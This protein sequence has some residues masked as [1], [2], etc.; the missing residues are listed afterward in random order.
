MYTVRALLLAIALAA[1]ACSSDNDTAIEAEAE[2]PTT[3]AAATTAASS[4]S[5]AA[6]SAQDTDPVAETAETESVAEPAEAEPAG[7]ES[8]DGAIT[9][10]F[11]VDF[12]SEPIVGTFVASEGADLLGCSSGSVE[13]VEGIPRIT[14][15]FTCDGGDRA[16]TFT[17]AWSVIPDSEGPGD[18]NGPWE[19][20]DAN[21]DFAGLTGDGLGSGTIE[22]ETGILSFPGAVEFGPIGPASTD[23]DATLIADVLAYSAAF[24]DGDFDLAW[25]MVSPRCQGIYDE[26][27]YRGSVEFFGTE[28][29]GFTASDVSAVVF[30]DTAAVNYNTSEEG[31]VYNAQPWALVDGNWHQDAC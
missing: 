4:S 7:A 13:Q 25:S 20:L 14:Q 28:L 2:S 15:A 18:F 27:D 30:G 9:I 6:P 26:T 1:T 21:G 24:G 17:F 12:A 5:T 11:E 23:A 22:G 16:G 3:T 29:A 19:V 10:E 8:G 31:L